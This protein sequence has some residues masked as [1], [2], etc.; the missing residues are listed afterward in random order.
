MALYGIIDVHPDWLYTDPDP[1]ILMNGDSDPVWDP[2]QVRTQVNKITK[3]IS[4][5]LLKVKLKY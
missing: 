2:D 4:N 3:L 1:Q 5:H